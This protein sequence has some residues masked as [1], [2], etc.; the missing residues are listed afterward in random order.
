MIRLLTMI[1][2]VAFAQPAAAEELCPKYGSC[3]PMSAFD[4][5]DIDRSSLVTRVC[6]NAAASYLVIRLKQTDY[7]YCE[8]DQ[9]TVQRLMS[10]SSMG[11]FYNAE[12]KDSGTDGRFSCRGRPQPKF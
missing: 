8:V 9:T 11:R 1:A 10:A 3:V 2:L 7:H 12:I 5:Q 4:C 6:Y